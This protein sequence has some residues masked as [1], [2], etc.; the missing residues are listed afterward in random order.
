M[1]IT[2][3][4]IAL[5]KCNRE[6]SR[7]VSTQSLS[8]FVVSL[9]ISIMFVI[10]AER[11]NG[12]AMAT[13]ANCSCYW[14]NVSQHFRSTFS[15]QYFTLCVCVILF[16]QFVYLFIFINVVWYLLYWTSGNAMPWT[17]C[18]PL[19]ADK[20]ECWI[21]LSDGKDTNIIKQIRHQVSWYR[22]FCMPTWFYLVV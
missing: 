10:L 16:M 3:C 19:N 17:Q 13:F 14:L 1:W 7:S 11:P 4:F 20:V 6:L 21:W 12:V 8:L 15:L 22:A 18:I 5:C 2:H 9:L